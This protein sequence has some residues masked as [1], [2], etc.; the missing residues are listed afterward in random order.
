MRDHPHPRPFNDRL[1]FPALPNSVGC[2]SPAVGSVSVVG[3]AP[4]A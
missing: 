3:C 2:A 4:A 1:S